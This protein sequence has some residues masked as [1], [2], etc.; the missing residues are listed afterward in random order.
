MEK[1]KLKEHTGL[2]SF[3]SL[4]TVKE[5]VIYWVYLVMTTERDWHRARVS[6]A[7]PYPW[8]HLWELFGLVLFFPGQSDPI[9]I[10]AK[11]LT[12]AM[13]NIQ[14]NAIWNGGPQKRGRGATS[15][16]I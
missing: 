11:M 7:E 9:F 14:F 4:L 15:R 10:I 2:W 1:L 16:V 3:G 5:S 12:I 8:L 13:I 6:C